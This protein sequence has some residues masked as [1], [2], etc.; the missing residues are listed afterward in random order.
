M[1]MRSVILICLFLVAMI[2]HG[3][4]RAD[5]KFSDG[6][7]KFIAELADEAIAK[8]TV[9]GL[10]QDER[11]KRFRALVHKHIDF[12]T[13]A[14]W[15]IGR[16]Y[17]SR[18]DEKQQKAYLS[19]YEDL[20]VATYANRFGD[21]AGETLVIKT[22]K[23]IDEKE[24]LVMSSLKRPQ[25]DKPVNIDWRVRERNSSFTI[26]DI[27][28]E[29]LSM[30]QTQRAEFTSFLRNHDGDVDALLKDIKARLDEIRKPKNS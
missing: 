27:M 15:V 6:A 13:I 10:P 26:V 30:A 23:T 24:A 11:E 7:R 18:A 14:H 20:M 21:Y 3:E 4:A 16:Q 5:E 12:E 22:A 19:L 8:L 2:A 1:P 9:K 25:A 29:G 17:W 28:I